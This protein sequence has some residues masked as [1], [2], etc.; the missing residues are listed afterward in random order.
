MFFYLRRQ[1]TRLGSSSNL[2]SLHCGSNVSLI[3]SLWCYLDQCCVCMPPSGQSGLDS[4]PPSSS[5]HKALVRCLWSD[6]CL[7]SSEVSSVHTHLYSTVLL[8]SVL[9]VIYLTLSDSLVLPFPILCPGS[10]GF[11][12]SALLGIS[13][14]VWAKHQE[15]KEK[16]HRHLPYIFG[17]I[18][19][20]VRV[21]LPQRFQCLPRHS[22]CHAAVAINTMVLHGLEVDEG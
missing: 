22:C 18:V 2:R 3:F 8:I 6:Q 10:W 11:S 4:G 16:T 12:F 13:L 14:C 15:N 9:S 20:V 19:S 1:L 17:I 5:V 7:C 21:F